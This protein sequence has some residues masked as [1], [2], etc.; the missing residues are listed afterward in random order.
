M[1]M[2]WYVWGNRLADKGSKRRPKSQVPR[3]K[4]PSDEM[5]HGLQGGALIREYPRVRNAGGAQA[6]CVYPIQSAPVP[7]RPMKHARARERERG[8]GNRLSFHRRRGHDVV[9]PRASRRWSLLFPL[10]PLSRDIL[11]LGRS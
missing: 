5:A 10:K 7:A 1:G 8:I 9:W 6:S 4:V 11:N 2:A 3:P